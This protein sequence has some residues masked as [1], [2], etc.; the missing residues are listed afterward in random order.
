MCVPTGNIHSVS[1]LLRHEDMRLKQPMPLLG[2]WIYCPQD[3]LSLTEQKLP[4]PNMIYT[5]IANLTVRSEAVFL[6][7]KILIE[8]K[9]QHL[10]SSII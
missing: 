9:A 6:L 2:Y 10:L 1:L 7:L 8:L 4:L 5:C 3:F